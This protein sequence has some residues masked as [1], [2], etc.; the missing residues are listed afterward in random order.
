MKIGV[1]SD[2]HINDLPVGVEY[3]NRL[4]VGPFSDVDLILHAGD[5]V[6]PDLL[7]CFNARPII[8]V[9][10]N[11]DEPAPDLPEKRIYESAGFRIGLVHGWGGPDGIV[12]NVL[13]SFA[14]VP[15]DA[16][17]FGHSHYPL[18]R[19]NDNILLFNPGS[20]T[21]RREAPFHSVGILT[22][23]E[24]LTGQIVNLDSAFKSMRK[25]DGVLL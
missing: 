14:D 22:L 5:I 19:Q 10:G 4:C 9:R 7:H 11:C 20:A 21:D 1:I 17:V 16:L 13:S 18:C 2:T 15:L 12:P 6:H 24:K 8:G 25:Y 23:G 3:L